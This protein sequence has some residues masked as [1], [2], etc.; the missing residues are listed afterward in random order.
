MNNL[1]QKVTYLLDEFAPYK[2]LSKKEIKLKS[3]P[4]INKEI[5]AEMSKRD[6]L[7]LKYSKMKNKKSEAAQITYEDYKKIRNEV[8]KLKRDSKVDYYRRF[9][10]EN[11]KKSSTIWKRIRSIVNINNTS[12]KD[13]KLLNEDGKNVYDPTKIAELLNKYFDSVGP[14]ID[15]KIPKPLKHFKDF[16]KHFKVDKTFFLKATTPREIFD[17]ILAF[18]LKKSLGPNSIPMYVLKI[19]NTFFADKL[20]DI[21]NLSFKT[22]I[23]PDLCKLAKVIPLF[24]KENPLLC[25]NYRPISLL[26]VYSKMFEK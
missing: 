14:N 26:P 25:E 20:C 12:R 23:F 6:K 18:D 9:F 22:G 16:M 2:K 21:I 1:H 10:E 4:W 11:K 5:L 3:K 19:A 8:T 17:I 13:I 24:K 15:K 7:L